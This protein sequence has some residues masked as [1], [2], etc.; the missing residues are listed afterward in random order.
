[1]DDD[2]RSR[3]EITRKPEKLRSP[4]AEL[5]AHLSEKAARLLH[6]RK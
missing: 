5:E 3:D 1:M 6:F 4:T 2:K